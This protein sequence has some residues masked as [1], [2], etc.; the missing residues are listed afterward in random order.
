MSNG[1]IYM[2]LAGTVIAAALLLWGAIYLIDTYAL[3]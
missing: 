1:E 3:V 2:L